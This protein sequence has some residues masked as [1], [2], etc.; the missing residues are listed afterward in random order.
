MST[1]RRPPPT[2]RLKKANLIINSVSQEEEGRTRRPY[3]RPN[4]S[5]F[6]GSHC[7]HQHQRRRR[8][9][10][11]SLFNHLGAANQNST[12]SRSNQTHA[13]CPRTAPHR[14]TLNFPGAC[15]VSVVVIIIIIVAS[16]STLSAI[17][18]WRQSSKFCGS[19]ISGQQQTASKANQL[20]LFS[21]CNLVA[22]AVQ[23]VC[24]GGKKRS[25]ER[26]RTVC[27]RPLR[28]EPLKKSQHENRRRRISL[29]FSFSYSISRA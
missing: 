18:Y 3:E 27:L 7:R 17:H 15:I 23:Y 11:V 8:L 12:P 6:Y 25:E 20:F 1:T 29:L 24:G 21:P 2:R 13:A 14:N 10:A 5:V 4:Q 19:R 26:W 16:G 22:V 9:A 28:H